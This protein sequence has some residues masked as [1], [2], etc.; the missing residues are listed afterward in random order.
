MWA[1]VFALEQLEIEDYP[2]Q[3]LHILLFHPLLPLPKCYLKC[4]F[5]ICI[6]QLNTEE[7]LSVLI[8]KLFG[9]LSIVRTTFLLLQKAQH[10]LK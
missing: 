9:M 7:L 5:K 8:F 10:P 1:H 2:T 3:P 4:L 6:L